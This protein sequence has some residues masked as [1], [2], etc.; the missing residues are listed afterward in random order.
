MVMGEHLALVT[1]RGAVAV[2]LDGD[3]RRAGA[4]RRG[5]AA[6][7]DAGREQ[8]GGVR[9]EAVVGGDE[10]GAAASRSPRWLRTSS[11]TM[12]WASRNGV[13]RPTSHSARS[14]A[15]DVSLSAAACI[16]SA[17]NVAVSIIPVIATSASATWST[18]SNSGSLSSCRSRL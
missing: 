2:E 13:P 6:D 8:R 17:T 14:V 16:R 10:V 15:D 9:A 4:A 5:A 18:E 3:R 11:P 1:E 7:G 12:A